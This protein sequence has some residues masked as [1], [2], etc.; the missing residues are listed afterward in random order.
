MRRPATPTGR[1]G[2]DGRRH[3]ALTRTGDAAERG[4]V[5]GPQLGQPVARGSGNL[6]AAD[7]VRDLGGNHQADQPPSTITLA[8]VTYDDAS[9]ARKTSAPSASRASSIRPMGTRALYA[10]RNSA[11]WSFQTPAS[12]TV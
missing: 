5:R 7:E 10:S 11:G 9:A 1:R 2:L 12:V 6:V 4:P 8:P 3:V